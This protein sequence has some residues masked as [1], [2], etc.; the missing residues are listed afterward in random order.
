MRP[1]GALRKRHVDEKNFAEIDNRVL[2]CD[3]SFDLP[4][5]E[6]QFGIGRSQRRDLLLQRIEF[7]EF[8]A[9][10][11]VRNRCRNG[12]QGALHNGS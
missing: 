3:R 11:G 7:G 6:I 2:E 1:F 12:P 4:D 10:K 5:F 9:Q 8:A